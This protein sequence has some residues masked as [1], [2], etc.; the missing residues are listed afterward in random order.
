MDGMT[1]PDP[2]PVLLA[3]GITDETDD[4]TE[5]DEALDARAVPPPFDVA[6]PPSDLAWHRPLSAHEL[7]PTLQLPERDEAFE[8]EIMARIPGFNGFFGRGGDRRSR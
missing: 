2:P 8:R 4:T 1:L 6:A 3:L 7:G 5:V